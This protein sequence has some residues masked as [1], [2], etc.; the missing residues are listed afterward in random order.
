M[1]T[2]RVRNKGAL[3][4]HRKCNQHFTAANQFNH[5]SQL[6]YV[7]MYM[8]LTIHVRVCVHVSMQVYFQTQQ[9]GRIDTVHQVYHCMSC[10]PNKVPNKVVGHLPQRFTEEREGK[11][12]MRNLSLMQSIFSYLCSYFPLGMRNYRGRW[13]NKAD[14]LV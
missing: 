7:Y 12:Q 1:I 5:C 13:K 11:E 8:S 9:N 6:M 14:I 4:T 2:E 3:K 10:F